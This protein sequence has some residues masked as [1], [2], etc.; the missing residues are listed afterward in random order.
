MKFANFHDFNF[1][2][3]DHDAEINANLHRIILLSVRLC[4]VGVTMGK[5]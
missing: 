2:Q 5:F 3:F 1:M 4:E